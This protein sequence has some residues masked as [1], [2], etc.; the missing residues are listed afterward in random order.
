[1]NEVVAERFR[2]KTLD[3][4]RVQAIRRSVARSTAEFQRRFSIPASTIE[5]WEQGRRKPD[6]AASLL[7]RLIEADPGLVERVAHETEVSTRSNW[8]PNRS[9]IL[10][11]T[12]NRA[13]S[14]RRGRAGGVRR[15]R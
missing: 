12:S 15:R 8:L 1:M 3:A 4:K 2:V 7:F 14:S 9:H 11:G 10:P 6:P 13:I 5:N